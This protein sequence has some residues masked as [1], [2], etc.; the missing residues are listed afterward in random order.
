[1]TNGPIAPIAALASEP[2]MSECPIKH[3]VLHARH[4]NYTVMRNSP[5]GQRAVFMTLDE[6]TALRVRDELD[7]CAEAAYRYGLQE[8]NRDRTKRIPPRVA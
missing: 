3:A 5:G 8:A 1:M 2:K 6:A 7:R 4:G